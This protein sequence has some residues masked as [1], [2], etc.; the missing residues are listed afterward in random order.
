MILDLP[1]FRPDLLVPLVAGHFLGDFVLQADW[2]VERKRRFGVVL[3]HAAIV[4][5]VSCVLL[6]HVPSWWWLFPTLLVTHLLVDL[7]KGAGDR[8]I[9]RRGANARVALFLLDQAAHLLVL[10]AILQVARLGALSWGSLAGQ[11][12]WVELFG[13]AY[14]H[15]LVL[16]TGWI[17]TAPAV[18]VLLALMLKRFEDELTPDQKTGL[19]GGGY[20]I[21]LTERSLIYLFILVA[22]PTGIGFLA[23]AKSVF[24][25]GELREAE[26]R[27]LAEYILIGTLMS[28][29]LA[30][31]FGL[32][33][34][35]ALSLPALR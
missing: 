15:A 8:S 27:K 22:E 31:V 12:V 29:A 2:M 7:A 9:G 34:R 23:A 11:G 19:P 28:F 20:W 4:A 18:G 16:L 33:T 13:R 1:L 10:A 21:G 14:L 26:E 3:L 35:A 25:I 24:R 32:L 30:M 17:V 5:V 6:G